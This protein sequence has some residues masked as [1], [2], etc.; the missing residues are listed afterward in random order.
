MINIKNLKI[1]KR[2]LAVIITAL[3]LVALIV[4]YVII[5]AV[6]N[7]GT[8][9]GGIASTPP[10]EVNTEIGESVYLNN[11]VAYPYIEKASIK[12]ISVKSDVDRFYLRRD[13]D[14]DG[15][16]LDYFLFYFEPVAGTAEPYLPDIVYSENNFDYTSFYAIEN[17]DGLNAYKI[18]YLCAALGAMFYDASIPLPAGNTDEES[19][20]RRT[21]LNRYG[22]NVEDREAILITYLD[23]EGNEKSYRIYIGDKLITGVG[24]Y[25]MIEGRDVVYTSASSERLSY[26]LSGF[27]SFL[28]SRIVAEGLD[29]D[30][31]FAPYLTTDYKQWTTVFHRAEGKRVEAG[32]VV[33]AVGDYKYPIYK[34]SSTSSG[35]RDGYRNVF[36][37]PTSISLDL[38]S[39]S[40]YPEFDALIDR[41]VG[42]GVG[43]LSEPIMATVISNMNEA[44]LSKGEGDERTGKYTYV[45]TAIESVFTQDGEIYA[46]GTPVGENS[47]I[48]VQYDY[49]I[50]GVAESTEPAHAV[51]DLSAE[52]VITAEVKSAL[53]SSSV[54][55]LSEPI[56]LDGVYYT[57]ENADKRIVESVIT[58]VVAIYDSEGRPKSS[59]DENS[60]VTYSYYSEMDG[61]RMGETD[62]VT[63]D[64]S[65]AKS[66][67]YLAIKNELL[68]RGVGSLSVTVKETVYCQP[69][70]DFKVYTFTE[71]KGYS[72]R[73]L[74]TSFR[75]QNESERDS[76]YAES[77]YLNT[78]PT[79][80]KY[81]GYVI[82]TEACDFV[83]RLLGGINKNGTSYKSGGLVGSETVAVG[84]TP[85][86]M[87]KYG[88][89]D[90]HTVYFEM[91]R[92]ITSVTSADKKIT[93][94]KWHDTLGFTLYISD[95][96]PDGTRYIG[97]EMYDI[98]VKIADK[99]FDY[100]ES[101]FSEF[102][103]RKSLVMIDYKDI[104]GFKAEFNMS[105]LKGK[106]DFSLEHKT[107]Y[108]DTNG[109]H[110]DTAPEGVQSSEY[111]EVSID[112]K[113]DGFVPG[114]PSVSG[115]YTETALS[116]ILAEEGRTSFNLANLYNR[117]AGIPS[118]GMGLTEKHDTLGTAS[119]K[120][121]LLVTYSTYYTGTVPEDEQEALKANSPLLLSLT[122][123]VR[124][125]SAYSY[126]YDFY[127]ISD[128]E[129]MV[130]TY[131]VDGAGNRINE[132]SDFT[133]STFAFKKIVGN[134]SNL[135][136]GKRLDS[137]VGYVDFAE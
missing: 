89:Y 10:P 75:F 85:D 96:Q 41:L 63:L 112:V 83:V 126:C 13:E 74:V 3:L 129:V 72:T 120:E 65:T 137:D 123:D 60:I 136:N 94:Y 34:S 82:N 23:K 58:E 70:R 125:S 54:G 52:S 42:T 50:D 36:N 133:V 97:S 127:R 39:L 92:G 102:W 100:L 9:N 61:V 25:Y 24:Y 51:I 84:L 101:S 77:A 124:S 134:I 98:V 1:N 80:H 18:D 73:E 135:L 40:A 46:N 76:F 110:Y 44:T 67:Y 48:K 87:I 30:K 93:D 21:I 104:D 109:Y 91:P 86:V 81:A 66:G 57:E 15:K 131:R 113:I 22:L 11:A 37:T 117:V 26:A 55:T 106:Y 115:V 16:L 4:T 116:R 59:I 103:A 27:E 28:H 121:L 128:R 38:S 33:V 43:K 90:G 35:T 62:F 111:N 130:S 78:L 29:I 31:T 14:K 79:N 17:S 64:L 88:L 108:I 56:V 20:A 19:E 7:A 107:I 32:S 68:G 99:D 114:S 119:F 12:S 8:G 53:S 47:L 132:V 122:F 71:I 69:F 118:G 45:I 49:Y 5:D 95:T 105:D 2:H 6:A